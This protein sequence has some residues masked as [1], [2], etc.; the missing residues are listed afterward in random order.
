VFVVALL[1]VVGAPAAPK[2]VPGQKEALAALAKAAAKHWLD[3]ATAKAD[4][5]Q[6]ARAAHLVRVLPI[7]RGRYVENALEQVAALDGRL[8]AP[9]AAALFGQLRANDDWFAK[10]AAPATSRDI[11]DS[12]GIV[13]RWFPG[14]C[15][16][17]HPLANFGAL[18]NDVAKR[19]VAATQRLADA[20]VARGSHVGSGG[21]AWEYYFHFDGGRPGWTSGMAQAV[22]AQA[23][24]RAALLVTNET[25]AYN[26]EAR[27]AYL[28]IPGRLTTSVSG[29]PWIRL[30]SFKTVQVLNAQL[31]SV[32]SLQSY[33]TNTAD[34]SAA[35]LAT[36]MQEAAAA[37]LPQFDTGYWMDYSLAGAPSPLSYYDFVL[38]LLKKLSP[39]DSR[40]A[41]ARA[42]FEPYL[43]QAPAFQVAN[44]PAG[45][46]R[47]WLSKP[48][49]VSVATGG[50]PTVRLYLAGGWHTLRLPAPK[51]AGMYVVKVTATDP[52]G[53]QASFTALPLV[54]VAALP[55][56]RAPARTTAGTTAPA[57]PAF[58]TGAGIDSA[59]QAPQAVSLGLGLV[60]LTV[61]WQPGETTADPTFAASLQT[62]PSTAG[63]V[64]EVDAGQLPAD[65]AGRSE[66]AQY[67]ASLAQ[68]APTLRDL[69]L[70]PAPGLASAAAYA[71]A[72]AAVRTAVVAARPDVAVGPSVDGSAA[73]PQQTA[74]AL[75]DELHHDGAAAD[76]VAFRPAPQ[77]GTGALAAGNVSLLRSTFK[78]GLGTAPPVL[79]DGVATPTTVP[80]SELGAYTGGAPPTDGAV[81]AA[82]QASAYATAIGK[83]SCSAGVVGLVLD[84]L[85]DDGAAPEPATGLYYASGDAKPSATAVQQEAAA[86]ARGAVVCPGL[87]AP[88]R[89]TTL[90][91]PGQLS[92]TSQPQVT[93]G[94][95]RDCLYLATLVNGGGHP[96]AAVRGGLQGGAAAKTIALPVRK[97]AA[98]RYRVD[99]RL[100]SRVNPGAVMR[101]TSAWL[102]V[103]Q[104]RR[105]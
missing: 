4:R 26:L 30:Y 80:A 15:F 51:R 70:T 32:L 61:P 92:R 25:S 71:D 60:R 86:V 39:A 2:P 14:Q 9:R 41:V 44:A 16:E 62:L 45:D 76:I 96:V 53:N 42:G 43:H 55:G 52:A 24:A 73:Q 11:A 66:L 81:S 89:A 104:P 91:L 102:T 22:A 95:N 83:A 6:I 3:P 68:Q 94:C 31:Q 85:V 5:G 90:T 18:N 46:V 37:T 67:A 54:R 7:A 65:D 1:V 74:L 93:L 33:A 59:A 98:G 38:Q 100:V 48:A 103:G 77:A 10:Q 27:G 19:D 23:F 58:V 29:G 17:F 34:T 101:R 82:S 40:F 13:Y 35:A 72:L 78:K 87:A 64:L 50:G 88:V 28:A 84:R 21:I 75:A 105:L 36:Q 57:A 69:V 56:K 8:T 99:V 49:W 12:D 79:L 20:L 47:F 97:L 63:L